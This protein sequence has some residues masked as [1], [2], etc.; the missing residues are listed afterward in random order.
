M[1]EAG[2][3]SEIDA[4]INCGLGKSLCEVYLFPF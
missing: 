3:E 2:W 1:F 4:L